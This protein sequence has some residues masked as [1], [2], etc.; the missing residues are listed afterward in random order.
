MISI[1]GSA[2]IVFGANKAHD[3]GAVR[4]ACEAQGWKH[5]V[6][7][8]PSRTTAMRE[9]LNRV[10]RRMPI[11]PAL[12]TSLRTVEAPNGWEAERVRK[13]QAHN[14]HIHLASVSVDE[15]EIVNL[16]SCHLDV[17]AAALAIEVQG[18]YDT[19]RNMMS[20]SQLRTVVKAVVRKLKGVALGAANLYYLPHES[21]AAFCQWRDD[22]LLCG[23][24]HTVAFEVAS[25]AGT[26]K[27]IIEQLNVEV[28]RQAQLIHAEICEGPTDPK[29]IKTLIRQCRAVIDKIRSYEAAL[30][31]QLDWMRAP[32]EAAESGL[33]VGALLS[34]SV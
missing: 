14:E 30:G 7:R 22:A 34:V 26:V 32:L 18:E 17:D 29:R 9:A 28:A 6:N 3:R 33:S 8:P 13:G 1:S 10:A 15:C 11:E 19:L 20:P 27:H 25:D 24:Y 5:M 23:R 31:Q 12:P 4:S 16:L 21:V 2:A